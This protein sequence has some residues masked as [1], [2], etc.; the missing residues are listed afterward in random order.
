MLNFFGLSLLAVLLA[1][2]EAFKPVAKP[3]IN[4][5]L[6]NTVLLVYLREQL[7]LRLLSLCIKQ[8]K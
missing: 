2:T 4:L 6:I 8:L 3:K 5:F 1:L 7:F